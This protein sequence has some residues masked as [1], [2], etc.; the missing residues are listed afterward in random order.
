MATTASQASRKMR[1]NH[2]NT[3]VYQSQETLY[4]E[5]NTLSR[6]TERGTWQEWNLYTGVYSTTSIII[7]PTED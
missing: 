2:A 6:Q 4:D 1:Q 7:D 5:P 3:T